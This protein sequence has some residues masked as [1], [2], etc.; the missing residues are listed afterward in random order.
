MIVSSCYDFNHSGILGMKW[1]VRRYQNKDG[2]LTEAGKRR[3]A[4]QQ[5]RLAKKDAEES[6]RAKMYYGDGAGVRRRQIKAI[7]KQRSKD[8]EYAKAYEKYLNEQDMSKHA[9][10]AR[11]ERK[12]QDFKDNTKRTIRGIA[13]TITGNPGR[14]AGTV[15]LATMAA[16]YAHK[17]GIDR[18]IFDKG[19]TAFNEAKKYVQNRDLRRN[20]ENIL[21]N[22]E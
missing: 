8:P 11:K 1:G 16:V 9:V 14:A 21:K 15:A 10:K 18:M 4:K 6:A 13:N 22:K 2:T 3:Y 5:D 19:K 20:V 17:N 12:R 7:V